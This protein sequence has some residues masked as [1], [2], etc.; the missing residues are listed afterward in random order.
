[1]IDPHDKEFDIQW[2]APTAIAAGVGFIGTLFG[3]P[4]LTNHLDNAGLI[5]GIRGVIYPLA[6]IFSVMPFAFIAV[7]SANRSFL[8]VRLLGVL[9][10]GYVAALAILVA[11]TFLGF[12]YP[13]TG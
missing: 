2:D 5:S 7:K 3:L 13:F 8:I 4:S 11:F 12:L 9:S 6:L 1:M 10:L